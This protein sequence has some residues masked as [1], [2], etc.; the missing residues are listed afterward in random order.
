MHWLRAALTAWLLGVLVAACGGAVESDAGIVTCVRVGDC[1]VGYDCVAGRCLL[2]TGDGG[3]AIDAGHDAGST[4][5]DASSDGAADAESIDAEVADAMSVDHCVAG[6]D[7]CGGGDDDCDGIVDEDPSCGGA[8]GTATCAGSRCELRCTAPFADCDTDAANGCETMV[9][10]GEVC[11]RCETACDAPAQCV[12]LGGVARCE[13]VVALGSRDTLSCVQFESGR[14]GCWGSNLGGSMGSLS[15][16]SVGTPRGVPFSG[17]VS[18]MAITTTNG[19]AITG[20]DRAAY[21]WGPATD[22]LWNGTGPAPSRAATSLAGFES[23]VAGE[24]HA[25]GLRQGT[26]TCWGS[27]EAYQVGAWIGIGT[28]GPNV[29]R[30]F[31]GAQSTCV[32]EGDVVRCVGHNYSGQLGVGN[33]MHPLASWS[34]VLGVTASEVRD[35]AMTERHACLLKT[36]GTIHC[37]G[38]D[39]RGQ[40]GNGPASSAGTTQYGAAIDGRWLAL[41]ASDGGTCAIRDDATHGVA[42]W[43]DNDDGHLVPSEPAA[44]LHSPTTVPGIE[45]ATRIALGRHGAC[46][47]TGAGRVICWGV[48]T[49]GERGTQTRSLTTLLPTTT[50]LDGATQVAVSND[51]T[52]AVARSEV[53]CTGANDTGRF[54]TMPRHDEATLLNITSGATE[55]QLPVSVSLSDTTLA[56]LG[57][58][59]AAAPVRIAMMG[60]NRGKFGNDAYDD[61][62]TF[63]TTVPSMA[64]PVEV[65]LALYHSCARY[66]DGTM[67]CW[68]T[69]NMDGQ[70]GLAASSNARLT[71]YVITALSQVTSISTTTRNTCSTDANGGLRCWG[72]NSFS[73]LGDATTNGTNTPTAPMT[74]GSGAA[75]AIGT[76]HACAYDGEHLWCWGTSRRGALAAN[77]TVRTTP[78]VS[79]T[80]FDGETVTAMRATTDR[81]CAL[82]QGG[83]LFCWGANDHGQLGDGTSIDR[84]TPIEV[85]LADVTDVAL[86]PSHTCAVARGLLYC[87]GLDADGA[88]VSGRNLVSTA[89]TVIGR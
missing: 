68:G 17:S 65:S 22:V 4:G 19:C 30:M 12:S 1:P 62:F 69:S 16:P 2:A 45:N 38:G 11:P 44:V 57:R 39:D 82:V 86:A 15:G 77:A 73:Q 18:S 25:C 31:A 29:T 52:C 47:L 37:A 59:N 10:E 24:R 60:M 72:D 40:L 23:L 5:V 3:G 67:A 63:R 21:C 71:P 50:G 70:M 28:R 27:H 55:I 8:N 76:T 81:S 6:P 32:T 74:I 43:G 49:H 34:Q 75:L 20:A 51:G 85:P 13:T 84:S 88:N 78:V 83:R 7:D 56:V 80:P 79:P 89:N 53:W 35:I 46:V 33:S 48:D 64:D 66:A 14:V 87:W 61:A 42:C 9:A 26:V 41:S 36:A 58:A 54:G